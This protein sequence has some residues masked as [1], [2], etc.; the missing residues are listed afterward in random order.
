MARAIPIV[1]KNS[2]ASGQEELVSGFSGLKMEGGISSP[3]AI[4]NSPANGKGSH[5]PWP[6]DSQEAPLSRSKGKDETDFEFEELMFGH[7][8]HETDHPE[9]HDEDGDGQDEADSVLPEDV[10]EKVLD[11]AKSKVGKDNFQLLKLIGQGAYGKVL[12]RKHREESA[13]SST[14]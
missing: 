2:S 8:K 11:L 1:K 12:E 14:Q 7:K 10:E 9:G 3:L 5:N 6:L 4:Y 13:R